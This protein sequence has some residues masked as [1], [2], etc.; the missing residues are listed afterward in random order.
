MT[1]TPEQ[2]L[3][4]FADHQR[5]SAE[6]LMVRTKEGRD[7]PLILSPAQVKLTEAI[8]RQ[9]RQGR[10]VRVRVCKAGQ[11]H[12]SYACVSHM[13]RRLAFQRGRLGKI[14]AHLNE[15]TRNLHIYFKRMYDNVRGPFNVLPAI[16]WEQDKFVEFEG[17]GR[18]EFGSAET[19]RGGRSTPFQDLHLSET[20]FWR[21]AE[22]LRT[23]LLNRVPDLPDTMILDESTANGASGAFYEGWIRAIEHPD[24]GWDTVFFGWHEHPEYS[25]E[26][27]RD[28]DK[29]RFQASM[30]DVE[31]AEQQKYNL[32]LEQLHW[33]RWAI[34]TKC[35][36][37]PRRF[38]Q[39]F[40]GCWEEAFL[41]SG[42][43]RFDLKL[44]AAMPRA[45]FA[46]GDLEEV[47]VGPRRVIE[48][49]DRGDGGGILKVRTK[50]QQ[51]AGYIIGADSAEGIDAREGTGS[52]DPDYSVA[53]VLDLS[54]GRQVAIMRARM[55]P[56]EFAL[57]LDVLGRWY[58]HAFIVPEINSSGIGLLD[59]LLRA[60]Y[61]ADLI[62]SQTLLPGQ[63]RT[64]GAGT[65]DLGFRTTTLT[66]EQLISTIDAALRDRSVTVYDSAT[67]QELRQFVYLN[68]KAQAARGC[69]DDCVMAL[70]LALMGVAQ[71][72]GRQAIMRPHG[73]QRVDKV[74]L[75][76][77]TRNSF[78]R[79]ADYDN[80]RD[81]GVDYG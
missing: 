54:N 44:V 65:R 68:G 60:Q 70:G 40:P 61:P 36:N 57:W 11:V 20:A 32:T 73:Q 56:A 33:R 74:R 80:D 26:F 4:L 25:K 7:K 47:Q 2:L 9:Q 14:Y 21:R 28:E 53:Q 52:T 64:A 71:A 16:R 6:C 66:R 30:T 41:S 5:F 59:G 55:A 15:A 29:P 62:Y 34:G 42:R 17:G 76:D 12:M 39:E 72:Q 19:T 13:V 43:T 18:V 22:D 81:E 67:I 8:Q 24:E 3:A 50:P 69:H 27:A 10:P 46:S 63:R 77:T 51:G 1:Q 31:H 75:F 58:N 37:D 45:E 35:E 49:L 38:Q 79:R 48:F 78:R 23:G